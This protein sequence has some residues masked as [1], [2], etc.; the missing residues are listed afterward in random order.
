MNHGVYMNNLLSKLQLTE[1]ILAKPDWFIA[2]HFGSHCMVFATL[3]MNHHSVPQ[4]VQNDRY[5]FLILLFP[6]IRSHDVL[7]KQK[8]L[9]VI[10]N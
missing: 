5:S 4:A 8:I 6:M 10:N 7:A 9:F 3:N 1:Q 2:T